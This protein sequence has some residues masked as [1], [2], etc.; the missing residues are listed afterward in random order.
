MDF[1]GERGR[2]I[3]DSKEIQEL[4]NTRNKAVRTEYYYS[5]LR[6]DQ[7]W[8]QGF[9]KGGVLSRH[10]TLRGVRERGTREDFENMDCEIRRLQCARAFPAFSTFQ[11]GKWEGCN[12]LNPPPP[13][14]A[15]G[16]P[17]LTH[18]TCGSDF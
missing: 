14:S 6:R 10:H 1:T 8:I 2:V 3:T 13:G 17:R 15:P 18:R 5:A 16:D 11:R 12:S 4:A 9:R 7:G